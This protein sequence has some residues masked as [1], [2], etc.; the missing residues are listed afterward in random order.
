MLSARVNMNKLVE[1]IV[2]IVFLLNRP[3]LPGSPKWY[4]ESSIACRAGRGD[5][6]APGRVPGHGR[7]GAA[8]SVIAEVLRTLVEEQTGWAVAPR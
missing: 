5:R 8:C 1:G 4:P 3:V 2:R 6:A 7:H